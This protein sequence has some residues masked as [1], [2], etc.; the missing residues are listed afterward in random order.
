MRAP[1]R[2]ERSEDELKW[3]SN[4]AST[5]LLCTNDCAADNAP[6]MAADDAPNAKAALSSAP[7][8]N[9]ASNAPNQK[10]A[11]SA[12]SNLATST[13]N[14]S[15]VRLPKGNEAKTLTRKARRAIARA[16]ARRAAKGDLASKQPAKL[17]KKQKKALKQAAAEKLNT[18]VAQEAQHAN[19]STAA[20]EATSFDCLAATA[21]A[22]A[23]DATATASETPS[24]P[25]RSRPRG[26]RAGKR[27]S[28]NKS[29]TANP[30]I[31][32]TT[33]I[34]SQK[35]NRADSP[36]AEGLNSESRTIELQVAVITEPYKPLN[37]KQ[38]DCI[39]QA[40]DQQLME[41]IL[42]PGR[43]I[44]AAFR[45]KPFYS[46][47]GLKMWCEDDYALEWLRRT[48]RNMPSP[49]EG[50]H[51]IVV[52]QS[53]IPRRVKSALLVPDVDTSQSG[54]V[55]RVRKILAAQNPWYN[56]NSWTLY[57]AEEQGRNPTRLFL[58]LGIL[59]EDVEVLVK[60]ERRVAWRTGSIYIKF[61]NETLGSGLHNEPPKWIL[62]RATKRPNT[63]ACHYKPTREFYNP[64]TESRPTNTNLLQ[65]SYNLS[66]ESKSSY[67]PNI[68]NPTQESR[69]S[70]S[71]NSSN[72]TH[73]SLTLKSQ[74]PSYN[75][76]SD[77]RSSYSPHIYKPT[78]EY[79]L[80]HSPNSYNPIHESMTLKSQAPSYNIPSESRSSQRPIS[81]GSDSYN[82]TQ[83]LRSTSPLQ[84]SYNPTQETRSSHSP[85]SRDSDCYN[86][87][88][89]RSTRTN[90]LQPSYNP[91]QESRSSHSPIFKGFDSYNRTQESMSTRTNL[92][93]PSYNPTREFHSSRP[94]SSGSD[95]YNHPESKI[96]TKLRQIAA[97][98]A[99]I[100]PKMQ[101]QNIFQAKN[102][103]QID[104]DALRGE[105]EADEQWEVR[106]RFMMQHKDR[107]EQDE[108]VTLAQLFT[109]IEFLGCK[110]PQET[111]A[112][113]AKLSES[114]SSKY[115]ESR[116]N[117]L[118]RTF[119]QASDA[120]E[121]KAKRSY[122]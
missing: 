111:M 42:A 87:P 97:N 89:S 22:A 18:C 20:N 75:I 74:A 106:R 85:I 57:H 88:E 63:E 100:A 101:S 51:L 95:S 94:I 27:H 69:L 86:P 92:L 10:A 1:R 90:L 99:Q 26:K 49:R 58:V 41:E 4:M 72:P 30:V 68:C 31:K 16:E 102:R 82:P 3:K 8:A 13:W 43:H 120:A 47:G 105:H 91:T 55:D 117:K 29:D 115:R 45:G 48:V 36:S 35:H 73:E 108:L 71:P 70:H 2:V 114:V 23:T 78:Q 21:N 44:V 81:R 14:D 25:K 53:E 110:Y 39:Q 79:R 59:P 54:E 116:K 19:T 103:S 98:D 15:V 9:S 52:R 76:P 60:R 62:E 24:E 6:V 17:T 61:F 66:Q 7:N 5:S 118:K 11:P 65:P 38:A 46:E 33:D 56:V 34:L 112:R 67:S 119:V 37:S 84:P 113:I 28:N 83:E 109:N 64:N 96:Q 93:Q 40:I 121:Q 122:H 80:S 50:T 12:P 77:F 32:H 104:V 107:F